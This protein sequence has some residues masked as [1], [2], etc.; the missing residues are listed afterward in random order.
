[1]AAWNVGDAETREALLRAG[2]W[3]ALAALRADTPARWGRMSA[4]QMVEHLEWTFACSTGT[5]GVDC[6]VPEEHRPRYLTFLAHDRPTPQGFENPALTSGLPPLAHADFAAAAAALRAEVD[7]FLA[8]SAEAP[9]ARRT[10]PLFGPIDAEQWS[11]THYKH[12]RHHFT[13]F[14]LYPDEPA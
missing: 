10:H 12:V 4:Q 9:G 7:R 5:R 14:G 13:Q 3:D 11:R 2:M 1:V 6:Y 8:L